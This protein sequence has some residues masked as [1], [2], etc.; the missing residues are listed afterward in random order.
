MQRSSRPI[1]LVLVLAGAL[2]AS[3]CGEQASGQ[4]ADLA[5]ATV[6]PAGPGVNRVQ[7]TPLAAKRIGI[8]TTLVASDG[9]G[10]AIPYSAVIYGQS[11]QAWTYINLKPNVFM[12]ERITVD[13]I[14]GGRALLSKGPASGTRVVTEGAA[15]LFGAEFEFEE[16]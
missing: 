5:P 7:L 13:R 8:Q 14:V 1:G 16:E 9:R 11:G 15:E 6:K 10:E 3:A 4:E 12:R 2:A